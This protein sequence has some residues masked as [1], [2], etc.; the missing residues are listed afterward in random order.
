MSIQQI[1]MLIVV[2]AACVALAII[3]YVLGKRNM[4]KRDEQQEQMD[5]VAQEYN[6]LVIDK[7]MMRL[8]ES[9]LPEVMIKETPW[10]ARRSKVGVVKAKIGPKIMILIAD[11]EIFDTIPVKKEIKATMSGIYIS[12]V[13]GIRGPLE[14]PVKKRN[15]FQKLMGVK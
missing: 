6:I 5:K 1:I 11:N 7:K 4:K 15:F 13:R 10:Y 2:A 3:L 12:S 9:G 14:K 8:K